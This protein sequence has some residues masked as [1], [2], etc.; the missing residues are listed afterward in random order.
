M[1]AAFFDLDKTVI[2]KA[3]IAAFGPT[4][5]RRGLITKR[6]LL[7]AAAIHLLFLQ[8]GASHDQLERIRRST[9]T[10]IRGWDQQEMEEIVRDALRD[11]LEPIIY[12]EAIDLIEEHQLAGRRVVIVSSAPEEIVKPMAEFLGVDEAIGSRAY[13]D[14][15]GRYTGEL[16]L[17][18]YGPAKADAV[19]ILAEE[20]GID[21]A[22]SYAYSDSHTDE[23]MLRLVGNPVAVNPDKDL[24]RI[25]RASKWPIS[26]FSHPMPPSEIAARRLRMANWILTATSFAAIGL[27]VGY[28]QLYQKTRILRGELDRRRR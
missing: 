12:R 26:Q 13:L 21:L 7:K 10:I 6:T 22:E 5:Y 3:S 8:F 4:L 1:Q 17:Y 19:R 11:V 28:W 2:A 25:A 23:P 9:L 24:I 14:S 15:Q 18:A 20:R 27:V 16:E